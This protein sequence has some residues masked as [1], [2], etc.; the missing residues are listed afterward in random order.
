MFELSAHQG[1]TV[2]FQGRL[3]ESDGTTVVALA[4]DDVVRFKI[5][6][7][8]AAPHLDVG[9]DAATADGSIVTIDDVGDEDTAAQY[10]VT[11]NEDDLADVPAG[12]Y[13]VELSV[14]DASEGVLKLVE[15]GCMH[16]LAAMAGEVGA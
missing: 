3:Y 5:G 13:D 7:G 1:R 9:S 8:S 11:L 12:T 2:A 14:Y 10:T 4:A 6:R 15:Q 16:V